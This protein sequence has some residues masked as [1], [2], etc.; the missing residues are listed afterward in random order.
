MGLIPIAHP[1]SALGKTFIRKCNS[2]INLFNRNC[3]N[4]YNTTKIRS[5]YQ[6]DL[7]SCIWSPCILIYERNAL[8]KFNSFDNP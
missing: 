1:Y 5:Q 2:F 6:D 4:L 3:H 7:P 8:W